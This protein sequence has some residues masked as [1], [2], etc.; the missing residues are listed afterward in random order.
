MQQRRPQAPLPISTRVPAKAISPGRDRMQSDLLVGAVGLLL[1]AKAAI[2]I[3]RIHAVGP[4][5][6]WLWISAVASAGFAVSTWLLRSATG[7]AA[8]LGGVLCL[9]VLLVQ[10]SN[11]GWRQSAMPSLLA[12]FLLTFAATR[13]GRARKQSLGLA[14]PK[15]GRRASQVIANLGV[16]GLCAVTSPPPSPLAGL[17]RATIVS[18]SG[19]T[20]HTAAAISATA[21]FA[22]SI[23]ALAEATADTLSSET[24]QVLGGLTLLLTSGRPV[25]PGTDGGISF[26][27]TTFGILGAAVV[28]LVSPL[29]HDPVALVICIAAACVGLF[30]DSL[31]GATVERR[32][33]LG[34]DL[35]NFSSTLVAALTAYAAVRLLL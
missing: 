19:R 10:A 7:P 33:W 9:D 11:P 24:G 25:P 16:A 23:A 13:F 28:V 4:L 27:G 12:L 34:N 22:A 29:A 30:V 14:E 35:V 20:F 31:L 21:L 8:T 5:P 6:K 18:T 15:H 32:G 1:I 3:A 2:E 26:A 17:A